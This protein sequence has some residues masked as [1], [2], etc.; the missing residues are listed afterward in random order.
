MSHTL[1]IPDPTLDIAGNLLQPDGLIQA[2][3][4]KY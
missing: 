3:L 1:W 2:I 4:A